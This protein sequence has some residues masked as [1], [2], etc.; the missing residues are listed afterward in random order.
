MNRFIPLLLLIC[1]SCGPSQS[2]HPL[3]PCDVAGYLFTLGEPVSETQKNWPDL[4]DY[5]YRFLRDTN[6]QQ[7]SDTYEEHS[8]GFTFYNNELILADLTIPRSE[9]NP[10]IIKMGE[11]IIQ[12]NA[13]VSTLT[14]VDDLNCMISCSPFDFDGIKSIQLIIEYQDAEELLNKGVEE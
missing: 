4:K 11:D 2:K 14:I 9:F 1:C 12:L 13:Q 6:I 3:V 7:F 5:S 10:S 8:F